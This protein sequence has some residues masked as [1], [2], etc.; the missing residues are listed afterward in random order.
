[1]IEFAAFYE[2]ALARHGDALAERL[3][4]VL[5]AEALAAIPDD[6]WLARLAMH[7]FAAGFRWRVIQAKWPGFE[8]AFSAFDVAVVA[9]LGTAERTALGEDRRIVRNP[10]KVRATCDNA[11]FVLETSARHGGFGRFIADWPDDD[12][13]GLWAHLKTHGT[14][15]GG[16]TGPRTLRA[17]GKDTFVLSGDV[18]RGLTEA[19]VMTATATSQKGRRQAQ[20]AFSTWRAQTGR[21]FAELSVIVASSTGDLYRR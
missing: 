10:Q 14:R 18:V 11:R 6:R 3:P 8:E 4:T 21:P 1:M 2:R 16:D 12:I 15:L 5:A 17:M 19:K 9:D 7:V 20:E 13:V